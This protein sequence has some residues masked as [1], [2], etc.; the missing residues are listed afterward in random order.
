MNTLHSSNRN[1]EHTSEAITTESR[2]K[3]QT[4]IELIKSNSADEE[5]EAFKESM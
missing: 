4:D 1:A 5:I 3:R 2:Q